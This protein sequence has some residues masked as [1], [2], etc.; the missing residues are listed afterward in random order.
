M[1][2]LYITHAE[3][4]I[5]SAHRLD[6]PST[7]LQT[8]AALCACTPVLPISEFT[9]NTG[10]ARNIGIAACHLLRQTLYGVATHIGFLFY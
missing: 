9:V 1:R 4:A 6:L 8:N 2:L 5:T 7:T 10:V 3:F